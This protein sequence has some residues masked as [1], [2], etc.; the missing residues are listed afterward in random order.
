ME[1]IRYGNPGAGDEEVKKAVEV[2]GIRDFIES[3]PDR[4]NSQIN[5]LGKNLSEGQKQR[6]SIA[7]ALLKKPDILI[8]DEPT[9]SLDSI[10]EKSIFEVLPE[11]LKDR[12]LFI[13][14]HRLA[15]TRIA[16]TILVLDKGALVDSGTHDELLS[17]CPLYREMV[18]NQRL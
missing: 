13:V 17:R 10:S 15:T 8:L 16:H 2:A 3:L 14:A 18:E 6:I 7:R 12:T 9:S 4:Y 11:T 5:E 1:N